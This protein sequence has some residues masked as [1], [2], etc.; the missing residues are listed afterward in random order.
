M[1]EIGSIPHEFDPEKR[2]CQAVIETPKGRRNKFKYLPES[3]L[4]GLS[5][6]LPKGF[7]FPVDFGFIPSTRA[8]DG[9]PLDVVVLMDEPAHVGCLLTVRL[10]GVIRVVQEEKGKK[11]QNDRLIAVAARSFDF[12]DVRSVDD[13]QKSLLDQLTE[14]IG[15]YNKNENKRDIVQGVEGPESAAKLLHDAA[16]KFR[17]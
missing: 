8:D 15:L 4:F 2:T 11:S 9:D 13:L 5:H 17:D 16:R 10:I 1:S 7:V 6:V 14:F 12:E 3:N